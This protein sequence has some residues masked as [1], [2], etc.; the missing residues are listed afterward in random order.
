MKF[1][2]LLHITDPRPHD[3]MHVLL[4]YLHLHILVVQILQVHGNNSVQTLENG[5]NGKRFGFN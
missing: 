3:G 4:F 2:G 1:S 5:S